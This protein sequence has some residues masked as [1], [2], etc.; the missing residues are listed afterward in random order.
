MLTDFKLLKLEL[1]NHPFFNDISIDFINEV[2]TNE[3]NSYENAFPFTT[4]LIGPNGTGK[5]QML[6]VIVDI[7]RE[8]ELAKM[9]TR[10]WNLLRTKYILS[11]KINTSS[12]T[13]ESKG[14]RSQI[15]CTKN[16]K[17]VDIS[18]LELPNKILA[19]AF[20]LN[21]RFPFVEADKEKLDD[22]I[23]TDKTY[24][25]Q[26]LGI[27]NRPGSAGTKSPVKNLVDDI[28]EIS[29]NPEFIKN[30]KDL[31]DFLNLEPHFKIL[32][33]PKFKSTFFKDD[34]DINKFNSFFVDWKK[35]RPN[36]E[37]EP[38][39]LP[40]YKK[41]KNDEINNLVNF[42]NHSK[43]KIDYKRNTEFLEY[44]ILTG[45]NNLKNDYL[46]NYY[47]IKHLMKLDLLSH[48]MIEIKKK[49]EYD[50]EN[51]SSG[52]YHFI[53]TVIRILANIQNNS[54][55]LI[56]EPE[57]SLHP[58]WQIKYI[59]YLKKIFSSYS[60]C[61]FIL[62]THSHFMV[63]DLQNDSSSMVIFKR[64]SQMEIITETSDEN[65]Y[66]WSTE[67]VLYNV[68]ELPTTRNYYLANEIGDILSLISKKEK[69]TQQIK[70]RVRELKKFDLE[71]KDIDPLKKIVEKLI[72]RF[73]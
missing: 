41:L 35:Y 45:D 2:N 18:N 11:Y 15:S 17:I 50:L 72:E 23:H 21:D 67:D 56:D 42:I 51:S 59:D 30:I 5:S 69:D 6:R 44:D 40:Y 62:A 34:I 66:G 3:K 43:F 9:G 54:L 48:P 63:S 10:S 16:S 39:S 4:L 57:M 25:Y 8:L 53:Y 20:I 33:K 31:L 73:G 58:N 68:F 14:K 38:Y 52:E 26:Y 65:T 36:R 27:R 70:N 61:H 32:F 7:F 47:L 37:T 28:I 24:I 64:N 71:L 49:G 60:S 19:S 55:V 1:F 22:I 46:N 29:N 13:V 12:Y